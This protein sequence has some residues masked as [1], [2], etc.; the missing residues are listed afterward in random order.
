[1]QYPITL[2]HG[3]TAIERQILS[4][5][6]LLTDE[7]CDTFNNVM[8]NDAYSK[9]KKNDVIKVIIS[10]TLDLNAFV[11]QYLIE[12]DN[13]QQIMWYKLDLENNIIE[14]ISWLKLLYQIVQLDD[15][16]FRDIFN[17]SAFEW[18]YTFEPRD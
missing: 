2:L 18:I 1:M 3:F 12:F 6:I 8:S 5:T 16:R 10:S 9:Y 7:Y 4:E 17:M 15:A 11:S 13:P 14:K